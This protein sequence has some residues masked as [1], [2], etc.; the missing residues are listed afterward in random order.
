MDAH[1]RS[2]LA[3]LPAFFRAA[4]VDTSKDDTVE[5]ERIMIQLIGQT[6]IMRL[7]RPL[8]AR[9]YRDPAFVR[10]PA[11]ALL[12]LQAQSRD[13]CV[14]AAHEILNL[15]RE[16]PSTQLL[17][18]WLVVFYAFAA[19]VVCVCIALRPLR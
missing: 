19:G 6:R 11:P 10:R 13:K 17:H 5:T 7:H 9:G 18:S 16:D 15:L 2:F 1:I 8:L 12:T 4:S 3:S 14:A